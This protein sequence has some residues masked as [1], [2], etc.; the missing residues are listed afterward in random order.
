MSAG[1][2]APGYL[3]VLQI[4][5]IVDGSCE[6]E[7]LFAPGFASTQHDLVQVLVG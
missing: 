4:E 7:Q 6:P 1:H 5:S 2:R 3:L